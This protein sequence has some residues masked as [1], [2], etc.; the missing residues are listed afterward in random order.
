MQHLQDPLVQTKKDPPMT[1]L[2]IVELALRR[3]AHF[4]R[5]PNC[6]IEFILKD[7]ADNICQLYRD[8]NKRELAAHKEALTRTEETL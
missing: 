1:D 7:I 3:A 6:D 8:R 2:E 5:E 4:G